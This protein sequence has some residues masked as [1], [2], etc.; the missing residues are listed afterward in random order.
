MEPGVHVG[1]QLPHAV[2]AHVTHLGHLILGTQRL[3]AEHGGPVGVQHVAV[4]LIHQRGE[5]RFLA[6]VVAVQ[7]AGGDAGGLDD[8]PQRRALIALFQ[9][10]RLC[11]GVDPLQRGAVCFSHEESSI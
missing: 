8:V 11:G 6:V 4:G 3:E 7:R 2:L 10:L 1:Q 9:K 5:Q